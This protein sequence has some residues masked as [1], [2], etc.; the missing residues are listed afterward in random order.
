MRSS[1]E[2]SSSIP[3]ASSIV[4]SSQT[5]E[6]GPR[7]GRGRD[8]VRLVGDGG[9]REVSLDEILPPLSEEDRMLSG[10]CYLAWPLAPILVLW[11]PRGQDPFV[12]FHA[13]QG[14]A[15]GALSLGG[16][17]LSG[18][19]AWLILWLLPGRALALS[20]LIGLGIFLGGVFLALLLVSFILYAAWRAAQGQLFHLPWLGGWAEARTR[21]RLHLWEP[22]SEPEARLS[23]ARERGLVA[24]DSGFLSRHRIGV[25]GGSEQGV[26]EAAPEAAPE[27]PRPRPRSR[28]VFADQGSP[29]GAGLGALRE[30]GVGFQWRSLEEEPG[31]EPETPGES[32]FRAW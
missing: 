20:G 23:L 27:R 3:L 15:L 6:E 25:E 29:A 14:L 8:W 10:L 13:L 5:P 9:R 22:A 28:G 1:G 31:A 30:G 32:G 7:S 11:G 21:S 16:A 17:G 4:P 24:P 2:G 18:A 19:L 12:R 26:V